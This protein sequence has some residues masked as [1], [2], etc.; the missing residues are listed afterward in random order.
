MSLQ[1]VNGMPEQPYACVHCGNNP[2]DQHGHQT[3]AIWSS[4]VDIDW[5][6]SVYTCWDCAELMA[7][8][9]DREPR[10]SYEKVAKELEALKEDFEIVEANLAQAEEDLEKIRAGAE[11]RKRV[12]ASSSSRASSTQ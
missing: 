7:D 2:A 12:L 4:G 6:N 11:A 10:A 1:V 5:G 9:I 3:K 8:L